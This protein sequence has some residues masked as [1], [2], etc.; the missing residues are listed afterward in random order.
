MVIH[1]GQKRFAMKRSKIYVCASV[2]AF[3]L[4]AVS[5][6]APLTVDPQ[7]SEEKVEETARLNLRLIQ[8]GET[9]SSISPDEGAITQL[10]VMAYR[11]SDGQLIAVSNGENAEDVGIEVMAGDYNIYVTANMPGFT[12]PV[13]ETDI[14]STGYETGSFSELGKGL[15]MCWSGSATLKAGEVTTVS[16]QL[17]RLV[18]KVGFKVEMGV[19]EG[20]EIT[21][22]RL[23]QGAGVIRPFMNEGSRILSASEDADGDFASDDDIRKLMNGE[24]IFFYVTENCQGKLL[25]GNDDPWAKVPENLGDISKLCTYIE[26]EGVWNEKAFYEGKVT[27]RF[28]LGEDATTD[29]NIRRNSIHNLT[30]YLEEESLDKISWKIDASQMDIVQWQAETSFDNNFHTPDNF[31]VT[32]NILIEFALDQK[33]QRYWKKLGNTFRLEARDNQG[34][35]IIR[36]QR[37]WDM[38]DGKWQAI[39]TCIRDGNFD[40]MMINTETEEIE[41]ILGSGSVHI[42]EIVASY[43][44]LFMDKQVDEFIKETEFTIN[45]SCMDI[46]LYLT[47]ID[48]LNLN[49]GHF[50]GCD[51]SLCNWEI[52]IINEAFGHDLFDK[53]DIETFYGECMD[54]SY[55]VRYRISFPN[56]GKDKTWNRMLTESLGKGVIRL[57]YEE[58]FSG[59]KG[60]HYLSLYCDPVSVTFMDLPPNELIYARTEFMY[61]INNP[62]KLPLMIQGL[63]LNTM[64]TDVAV[65]SDLMPI[66]CSPIEDYTLSA[67]LLVTRM[68]YTFCSL[69][70]NASYSFTYNKQTAYAAADCGISEYKIPHQ[71]AMFHIFDISLAYATTGWGPTINGSYSLDTTIY[72]DNYGAYMNCGVIFHSYGKTREIFDSKNG[73]KADF[74]EC[75]ELLSQDAVNAFNDIVEV[76]LN[77]DENNQLIARA[78]REIPLD[79]SISG[80]LK[81]HTRCVSGDESTYKIWGQYFDSGHRFRNTQRITV[82]LTPT[83]VDGHAIADS[84]ERIR[85]QEFYSKLNADDPDDFYINDGKSTTFREYLKPYALELDIS[86]TSPDGIPVALKGFS[87]QAIYKFTLPDSVTWKIG[88]SRIVTM[89]PSAFAGFDSYIPNCP[90]S[91]FVAETVRLTPKVSFNTQNIWYMPH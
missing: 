39:G 50:Y 18:S 5:C 23:K 1:L 56:E 42:P 69:E 61:V 26:M 14:S 40:V 2:M 59:A 79:I 63:K 8:S 45:G 84:F 76:T 49:Q 46:C 31:Y 4:A 68:P 64:R 66:L 13:Q 80:F 29:F 15:P 53:A 30:L 38:G 82:G 77:L 7:E 25:E 62:S 16:A 20:L 91:E 48:G 32:E 73:K 33:G 17:S 44:D 43:D 36:F 81:G 51:L 28:Y 85:E 74:N 6:T 35:T 67:P 10:Q 27:Y 87:G 88:A 24:D 47:D 22:I 70:D 3:A 11:K 75:G 54:D 78:T 34:N 37:P 19:L 21:S 58:T 57:S 89:V 71:T 12:A 83:A 60:N 55:A 72:G 41:Y 9:K 65:D 52:G 90:G 86:I